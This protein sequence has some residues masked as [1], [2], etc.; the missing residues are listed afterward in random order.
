VNMLNLIYYY[1]RGGLILPTSDD[2]DMDSATN[3]D[4][5]RR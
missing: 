1:F 4:L 5:K 2:D 3:C